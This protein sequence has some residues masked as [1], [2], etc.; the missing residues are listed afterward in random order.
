MPRRFNITGP[1]VPGRDFMVD[2]S[3]RLRRPVQAICRGESLCLT[4]RRQSGKTTLLRLLARALQKEGLAPV[5]CAVQLAEDQSLTGIFRHIEASLRL[6]YPVP[7]VPRWTA[8]EPQSLSFCAWLGEAQR[9]LGRPLVLLLDEYD[10]PPRKLVAGMLRSFRAALTLADEARPFVHAVVL[11][12]KTHIRDLR[13]EPRPPGDESRGSGSLWNVAL[14]LSVGPFSRREVDALLDDY[15][16]DSGVD[17][18][19]AA[20][21]AL[22]AQTRGQPYLVSRLCYQIDEQIGTPRKE[23]GTAPLEMPTEALVRHLAAQLPDEDPVHFSSIS[24]LLAA[25]KEAQEI[26]LRLLSGDEVP[27]CRSNEAQGYLLDAG[28]LIPSESR[29]LVELACPIYAAYLGRW[30]AESG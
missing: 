19:P 11:C 15:A 14:P 25:R 30:L 4:Q 7:S 22:Y 21:D 2:L 18:T 28:L 1:C 23:T 29:R 8:T 3:G 10:A 6:L 17:W 12:G 9:L 26:V 13:D 24:D 20:R 5:L 16:A 27:L